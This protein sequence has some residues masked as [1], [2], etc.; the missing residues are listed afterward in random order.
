M[1]VDKEILEIVDVTG[2]NVETKADR[3]IEVANRNGGIDNI[4]IVLVEV[5]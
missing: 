2:E 4:A 5:R 1:V 3:L